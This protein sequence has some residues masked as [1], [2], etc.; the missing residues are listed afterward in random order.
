M[1]WG[2]SQIAKKQL[3]LQTKTLSPSPE[4]PAWLKFWR[5]KTPWQEEQGQTFPQWAGQ[6]IHPQTDRVVR[7]VKGDDS[8]IHSF[9][10]SGKELTFPDWQ[11][12]ESYSKGKG[13]GTPPTPEYKWWRNP[14]MPGGPFAGAAVNPRTTSDIGAAASLAMMAGMEPAA[15]AVAPL[16]T[17]LPKWGSTALGFIADVSGRIEPT[18]S[19][20]II[21]QAT[22]FAIKQL[23][24][25]GAE[26]KE[27]IIQGISKS[28]PEKQAKKLVET[29]AKRLGISA[30]KVVGKIP[31]VAPKV[32]GA[33]PPVA[34]EAPQFAGNIRLGKFPESTRPIIQEWASA[35]P[36]E[37][38]TARRGV[39][40][41]AQVLAEGQKLVEEVG[42]GFGKKI[43]K[44]KPGQAWNAEEITALR[45]SLNSKAQEI[46]RLRDAIQGGVDTTENMLKLEMSLLEH[47]QLQQTVLHGVTAEAGR[48]LRA[49][50]QT[51]FDSLKASNVEK[52]NE[53]LKRLGGKG[54]IKDIADKLA[55]VDMNDPLAVNKFIQSVTKPK[56]YDYLIEIFY[57]SILS[58]PKTH[59]VNFG[60]NTL[61]AVLSPF[62]RGVSAAVEAPLA[63]FQRRP[64]QRFLGEV[65][66]DI[67][68]ALRG[69]PE[70]LRAA[71]YNI[72][73]GY[74]LEEVAKWEIKSKAFTG[75]AG[76]VVGM[77]T[78]FLEAAD[79]FGKSVNRTATLRAEAY[80]TAK[81]SGLKGEQF[82]TELN[83]LIQNPTG[84]MLKRA[85]DIAEYRLFRQKPGAVVSKLIK[86]RDVEIMGIPVLRFFV[87]FL[88]TPANL[89]K[90]GLERSPLGVLNYKMWINAAKKSPEAADQIARWV[91]GSTIAVG[92]GTYIADGK[93]TGAA[94]TSPNERDLFYRLGKQPYSIKVGDKW[95]SYQRIEPLN[96]TLAQVAAVAQSIKDKESDTDITGMVGKAIATISQNFISQTYMSGIA[97]LMNAMEDPEHSGG[98]FIQRW[99]TGLI[100]Y[101]GT[102]RAATQATDVTIRQPRGI[103]ESIK[104]GI[105][106]L[107]QTV[108]AKIDIFGETITRESPFWSPIYVTTEKD[109][110]LNQE[111]NNLG[112]NFGFVGGSISGTE[113]TEE[114]TREYRI[115]AGNVLKD[116]LSR[117][118]DSSEYQSLTAIEDRKDYLNSVANSARQL[119]RTIEM[120]KLGMPVSTASKEVQ[121]KEFLNANLNAAEDK[122]WRQYSPD[123]R[124]LSDQIIK[125]ENSDNRN[126]KIQARQLLMQHPEILSI[127]RKIAI[128]K[129]KVKREMQGR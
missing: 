31:E 42:G 101:S 58:N 7:S 49:F 50:R 2:E 35:H 92:V 43:Q 79:M 64:Q 129:A 37:I 100:P 114:Q 98:N 22:E 51:A 102:M 122:I 69:I 41:D 119:S 27:S 124:T 29:V 53:L 5:G 90:F 78:R 74:T 108:P 28:M 36:Q 55:K 1:N 97:D 106:G 65:A 46:I 76:I 94:P 21:Q 123:L 44:W 30:E 39:I 83:R 91:I 15:A 89:V 25:K 26:A 80:R 99:A 82:I 77:P 113:L 40:P 116:Y 75:K 96:Q 24:E 9:T 107:S 20:K 13:M 88:R 18:V 105:P 117:A 52:M 95:V 23:R 109:G 126:D 127:R 3:P 66:Q 63:F 121:A 84:E 67:F 45:G 86:L 38:A 71:L 60:S 72:K 57:N 85:S 56:W 59:I 81:M 61:T 11:T 48:S 34:K 14:Y 115:L 10:E 33:V 6:T 110:R 70:G 17:L 4:V 19:P 68:G 32:G 111:L 73:N 125:L 112:L 104:A 120:E 12:A 47:A 103:A 62:E 54:K 118:I 93:I 16:A 128:E 8:L 87:P